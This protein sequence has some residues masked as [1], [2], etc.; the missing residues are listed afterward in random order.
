MRG[1]P[2][3]RFLGESGARKGPRLTRRRRRRLGE[4]VRWAH[5]EGIEV[6]A[7][8]GAPIGLGASCFSGRGCAI[9]SGE[10]GGKV[11]AGTTLG[12]LAGPPER[13]ERLQG[14]GAL[15]GGVPPPEAIDSTARRLPKNLAQ[16]ERL[17]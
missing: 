12:L 16:G 10:P 17:L 1:N 2:H 6:G 4:R 14:G 8:R 11:K 13:P 9:E 7:A 3:V 5:L 15:S